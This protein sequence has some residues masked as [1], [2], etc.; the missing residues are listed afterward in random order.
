M[1]DR[2]S[3]VCPHCS[4]ATSLSSVLIED[5]WAY[6]PERSSDKQPYHEKAVVRAVKFA[7]YPHTIDYGL[8]EC[9]ACHEHFLARR[10]D[11]VD[12][13]QWV[14]VYPIPHAHLDEAVPQA[15]R[16]QIEEAQLCFSV[17]AYTGCLLVCR[18]AL[19]AVLRDNSVT[20][21]K[22]LNEKGA[23]ST[24]LYQQSDEVRLWANMFGHEDVPAS[25]PPDDCEQLLAYLGA[26]LNTVY[27]EPKR[28]AELAEKRKQSKG[29]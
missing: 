13:G 20:N 17:G 28:L 29:G 10:Q 27:V 6:I 7:E 25:I 11:Y 18:T 9:Q 15:I 24:L 14:A 1:A 8:Y 5:E 21:L 4:S 12:G 16:N 22:E 26:L 19:I 3:I 2:T 23:I